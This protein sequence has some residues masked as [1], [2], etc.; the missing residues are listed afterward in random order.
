MKFRSVH[1]YEIRKQEKKTFTSGNVSALSDSVGEIA[2]RFAWATGKPCV[3][4]LDALLLSGC[5]CRCFAR[6]TKVA[7][8]W[9]ITWYT[10]DW[11]ESV[12]STARRSDTTT[13]CKRASI[14]HLDLFDWFYTVARQLAYFVYLR[15]INFEGRIKM[16]SHRDL[17]VEREISKV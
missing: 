16:W 1:N 2:R 7:W 15:L 9:C 3:R 10:T 8:A 5:S 12:A 13:R 4:V 14:A 17:M 6:S 11:P